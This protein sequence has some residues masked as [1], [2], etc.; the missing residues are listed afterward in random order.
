[1]LAEAPGTGSGPTGT[2]GFR[3]ALGWFHA[4]RVVEGRRDGA[5]YEAVLA[6]SDP[7]GRR[8]GLRLGPDGDA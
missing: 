6:T 5:D 2:L 7:L 4:T 1:V 3:T 8:L